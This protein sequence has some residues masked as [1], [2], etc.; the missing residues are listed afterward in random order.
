MGLAMSDQDVSFTLGF[1][2]PG[3]RLNSVPV[4]RGVLVG[5]SYA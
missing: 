2:V 5:C 3:E 1:G 4:G